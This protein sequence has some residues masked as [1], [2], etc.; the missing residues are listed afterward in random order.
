MGKGEMAA[1]SVINGLDP[2]SRFDPR[3][4][5]VL[6]LLSHP[7]DRRRVWLALSGNAI[8]SSDPRWAEEAAG[9][10]YAGPWRGRGAGSAVLLLQPTS[11]AFLV[12]SR[13]RVAHSRPNLLNPLAISGD[14]IS[15]PLLLLGGRKFWGPAGQKQNKPRVSGGE[16]NI[17]N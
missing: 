2:A 4:G 5:K 14:L 11:S 12:P 3:G 7:G 9:E 6:L 16:D 13:R 8:S 1:C 15:L 10:Y 17:N